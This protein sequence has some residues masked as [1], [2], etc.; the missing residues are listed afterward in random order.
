MPRL[1]TPT[2]TNRHAATDIEQAAIAAWREQYGR[3]LAPLLDLRRR[4]AEGGLAPE[5]AARQVVS[6]LRT[7]TAAEPQLR[8]LEM[9][10][11]GAR[12]LSG[13][14]SIR[15]ISARTG[16][17]ASTL[18]RWR[19]HPG[20]VDMRGRECLPDCDAEYGWRAL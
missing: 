17:A 9:I 18:R 15:I 20:P 1:L 10:A 2:A 19:P 5:I 4:L 13:Q 11:V 3:A 6:A 12:V 16:I 8:R 14:T 7:L